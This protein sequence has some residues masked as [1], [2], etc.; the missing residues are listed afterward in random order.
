MGPRHCCEPW[1]QRERHSRASELL[2]QGSAVDL[3]CHGARVTWTEFVVASNLMAQLHLSSMLRGAE[4][5]PHHM[6]YT[7]VRDLRFAVR[8]TAAVSG[9]THCF[10][11]YPARFSP[12]FAAAVIEHFSKPGDLILDPYMGG[13]TTIVEAC[14]RDRAVVG[15]DIN[16][17][18]VFITRVKTTSLSEV[19]KVAVRLWAEHVVPTLSYRDMPPDLHNFI[20]P[21]RTF[22]LTL[23]RARPIKKAIALALRTIGAL[24]SMASENFARCALLNSA[25]AFLNGQKRAGNFRHFLD[26]LQTTV[27]RMLGEL[28]EFE[29]SRGKFQPLLHDQSASDLPN[30]APFDRGR[31]ANLVLTSPP[32]PGIHLLYH[33]W[34]V[35]GRRETPAPYWM[36][37]CYDGEGNAYYNFADRRTSAEDKYFDESLKTLQ[38][39][40]AVVAD[41]A[42]IAQ[43]IA[44]SDPARQLRRYLRNM[45]DAGF[46]ELR[47]TGHRRIW[48]DVPSRRWHA[49]LHGR[50]GGSREVLLLHVAT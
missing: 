33:R 25:Q 38:G 32:Y 29:Q 12:R 40:R 31:K 15:S 27:L 39:I 23:P 18:A 13:G 14:V 3:P 28:V 7:P 11:R 21:R 2:S 30:L 17:L 46:R 10:Y 45:S 6:G 19:E 16:S 36:A 4:S 22:N 9:L 8:D 47:F 35:D 1:G 37:N 5:R 41:D 20:C 42:V 24:P 50:T 44:F 43:L 49:N 48:R 34:Q 26:R